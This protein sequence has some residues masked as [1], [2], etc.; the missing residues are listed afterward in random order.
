MPRSYYMSLHVDSR[1]CVAHGLLIGHKQVIWNQ[2]QA[3]FDELMHMDSSATIAFYNGL[4][5]MLWHFGQVLIEMEDV[6]AI[7][8]AIGV[9]DD[10]VGATEFLFGRHFLIGKGVISNKLIGG[11]R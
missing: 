6:H 10:D 3:L 1:L 9:Q 4:T 8:R 11:A 7:A 5:D 2:A